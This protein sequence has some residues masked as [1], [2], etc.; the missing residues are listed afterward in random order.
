MLYY[1]GPSQSIS[2]KGRIEIPRLQRATALMQ[3]CSLLRITLEE[4]YDEHKGHPSKSLEE[5]KPLPVRFPSSRQYLWCSNFSQPQRAMTSPTH[6]ALFA[7][8]FLVLV[9]DFHLLRANPPL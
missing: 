2:V 9:M 3:L 8:A 6:L 4:V 1:R 5:R 7:R